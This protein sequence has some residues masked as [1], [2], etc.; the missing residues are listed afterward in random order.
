MPERIAAEHPNKKPGT[1]TD[2][3]RLNEAQA[4][5]GIR[6]QRMTVE[7]CLKSMQPLTWKVCNH[8]LEQYATTHLKSMQPLTWK[9][10]N[11][12]L[13]KITQPLSNITQPLTQLSTIRWPPPYSASPITKHL[14]SPF[15]PLLTQ[16][17]IPEGSRWRSLPG[18]STFCSWVCPVS[19]CQQHHHYQ[20]TPS[21][22]SWLQLVFY[23]RGGQCHPVS[24]II[25]IMAVACLLSQGC[26]M[27]PCHQSS[28]T[29]IMAMPKACLLSQGCP[30]SP[31]HQQSTSS[32]Q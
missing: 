32:R 5:H 6:I 26:P 17:Q 27:S 24:N 22:S 9:V 29:T 20:S 4:D 21:T 8:S 2:P 3:V 16:Q 30:V 28:S 10:C 19:P 14:L 13:G 7:T 1:C 23:H 11:H 15:M 25:I 12:S 31:C 18:P